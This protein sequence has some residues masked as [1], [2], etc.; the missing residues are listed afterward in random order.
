MFPQPRPRENHGNL[1]SSFCFQLAPNGEAA[2]LLTVVVGV[3]F[4]LVSTRFFGLPVVDHRGSCVAMTWEPR[5]D[6]NNSMTSWKDQGLA[7]H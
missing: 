2:C 1:A 4:G 7:E 3:M 5:S 6:G